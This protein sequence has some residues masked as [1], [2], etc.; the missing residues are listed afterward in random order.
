MTNSMAYLEEEA[1]DNLEVIKI[2]N[3]HFDKKALI[4][5]ANNAQEKIKDSKV[6]WIV[7]KQPSNYYTPPI[8]IKSSNINDANMVRLTKNDEKIFDL[9][10][11]KEGKRAT[12]ILFIK[13]N[14]KEDLEIVYELLTKWRVPKITHTENYKKYTRKAQRI[15]MLI[16]LFGPLFIILIKSGFI[17]PDYTTLIFFGGIL[18]ALFIFGAF[19][20]QKAYK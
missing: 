15:W 11:E 1:E 12:M 2:L 17:Y 9:Y 7:C 5:L 16:F 10:L 20:N 8:E 18:I 3:R 4:E 6:Q 13:N 14:L 19:I